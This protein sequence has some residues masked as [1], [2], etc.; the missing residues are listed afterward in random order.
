MGR[1][2]QSQRWQ[3]PGLELQNRCSTTELN[4]HPRPLDTIS[5]NVCKA[6]VDIALAKP[7]ANCSLLTGAS[8]SQ[9]R[10]GLLVIDETSFTNT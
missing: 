7:H 8:A 3:I 2:N 1:I 6:F 5:I 10:V 9:P 4:W